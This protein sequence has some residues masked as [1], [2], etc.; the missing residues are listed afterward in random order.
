LTGVKG[1]GYHFL[2]KHYRVNRGEAGHKL[3]NFLK[4]RLGAA[5]S[6]RG[7]KRLID[8]NRCRVNGRIERFGCTPVDAGDEVSILLDV[9]PVAPKVL[10]EDERM[11][12]I[13]KPAGTSFDKLNFGL[14][15]HRLDRDT[16]GVMLFAKS[17]D[18]LEELQ[19]AFAERRVEK[20]YLAVIEGRL[21]ET[22]GAIENRIGPVKRFEGQ[23]IHGVTS[24]GKW[25][26]T[27]WVAIRENLL[28]CTPETGRTHQ[29]RVHLASIGHPIVGDGQYGSTTL[30]SRH[31]LHC[32]RITIE[33]ITIE[34][35]PPKEFACAS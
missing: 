18:S 8:R 33:G 6:V 4:E 15:V 13:D 11:V 23:T 12:A 26:K 3:Q 30:A 34:S 32:E 14:P 25:A 20:S 35:P 16:S 2:V 1:E 22:E 21:K 7:V 5:Y 19:E 28:R 17:E 29:I 24:K 31:L 10:Y 9:T 27:T